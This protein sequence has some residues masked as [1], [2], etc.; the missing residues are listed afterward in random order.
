MSPRHTSSSWTEVNEE[1]LCCSLNQ[2]LPDTS[3]T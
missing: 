1:S 3:T 2:G